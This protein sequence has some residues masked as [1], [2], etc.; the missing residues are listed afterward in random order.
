MGS[1]AENVRKAALEK[2]DANQPKGEST[3]DLQ[4]QIAVGATGKGQSAGQNLKQS[5][6]AEQIG[7]VE[8]RGVQ[9]DVANAGLQ[10]ASQVAAK[11]AEQE[12]EIKEVA[13]ANRTKE[14]QFQ[15]DQADQM[16][17]LLSEMEYAD[18]QL[19]DRKDAAT[20]E[21][22]AANLRL[23][24]EK[25]RHDI[26]M[27]GT[28]NR[29][30]RSA[31]IAHEAARIE[32]GD[33]TQRLYDEI[34]NNDRMRAEDRADREKDLMMSLEDAYKVTEA[35]I[36]DDLSAA[37]FNTAKDLGVAGVSTAGEAGLFDNMFGGEEG[38]AAGEVA[39]S[40]GAG[41]TDTL[42]STGYNGVYEG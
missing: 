31:E 35:K 25:Y 38:T 19:D 8:A 22:I 26:E 6:I 16:D 9:Q 39:G 24:D 14:M 37:K 23:S 33:N 4:T 42:H 10:A 17:A 41:D 13:A 20:L 28:R 30:D 3:A 27:V 40:G 2:N 15:A 11:E 1:L 36:Q 21:L 18:E 5:N 34:E 7:M 12:V 32:I 29:L